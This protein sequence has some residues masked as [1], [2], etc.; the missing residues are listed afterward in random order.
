MR[1]KKGSFVKFFLDGCL[2]FS[3][4]P[5][6]PYISVYRHYVARTFRVVK[7]GNETDAGNKKEDI[8]TMYIY[9]TNWQ[10]M[11][12]KKDLLSVMV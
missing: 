8:S 7:L 10:N 2:F 3:T 9:R 4:G 6:M 12:A 5:F 1:R 11:P